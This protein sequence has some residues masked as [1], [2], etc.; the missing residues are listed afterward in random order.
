MCLVL[1]PPAHGQAFVLTGG[2]SSM[3]AAH[4]ASTEVR[5]PGYTGRFDFGYTGGPSLGFSL[6]HMYHG[7]LFD[8]GDQEI[9]LLFPTDLFD[10]SYYFLGRGLS[11]LRKNKQERLFVFAGA[12]STGFWAPFLN[13]AHTESLTTAIFYERKISPSLRWFSRNLFGGRQTSIQSLEWTGKRDLKIAMS[14]G[15]GN[16]QGYWASSFSWSTPRISVDASYARPGDT[17]TRVEVSAPQL[18]EN[19]RENILVEFKPLR[20]MRIIASRNNYLSPPGEGLPS[21]AAVNGFGIWTGI[22]RT[23]LYGSLYQSSTSFGKSDAYSLG[24]ASRFHSEAGGGSRFS[25]HA[26]GGPRISFPRGNDSGNPH[27]QAEPESGHN[28][29]QRSNGNF[30]RRELHFQYFD[31]KRGLPDGF[32]ALSACRPRPIQAGHRDRAAFSIAAWDSI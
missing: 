30:I 13:V 23:Q 4:G 6:L 25:G 15:V 5:T 18:T 10:R 7:V 11:A 24:G 22:S 27:F 1:G 3:F 17:F 12:T 14:A 2:S 26:C 21:R 16:N 20:N 28:A 19:D 8:A 31:V 9:R 32:S 29:R